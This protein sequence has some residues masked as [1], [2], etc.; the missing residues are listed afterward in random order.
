MEKLHHVLGVR[1]GASDEEIRAAFRQLAKQLH[2]DLRPDDGTAEQR[3]R[4]VLTAYEILKQDAPRQAYQ[5]AVSMRRSRRR[6]QAIRMLSVFALTVAAGLF[7]SDMIAAV[8]P[9]RETLRGLSGNN[10]AEQLELV[11]AP[12]H[13][14]SAQELIS[15]ASSSARV[16]EAVNPQLEASAEPE[17]VQGSELEGGGETAAGL[18]VSLS[19]LTHSHGS[20]NDG[21]ATAMLPPS[22]IPLTPMPPTRGEP[23]SW[24]SYRDARFGFA[25]EYP[26]E[27]FIYDRSQ[28]NDGQSSNFVSR[29]GRA[30]LVIFTTANLRRKTLAQHRRSLVEG[31]YKDAAF[32]YTPQR[33]SRFVLS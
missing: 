13:S 3:F 24:V 27:V 16:T 30:R 11:Q 20:E 31:P 17:K 32:D 26:T 28:S 14:S 22:E 15:V 33:S 12:D 4:D 29:D 1:A 23:P 25:L 18:G 2:P 7:W 9:S 21:K 5:A 10:T 19:T 8:L 6:A